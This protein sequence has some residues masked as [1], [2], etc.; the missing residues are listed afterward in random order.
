MDVTPREINEKQFRDAWR[1]YNQEEVDDFLDRVAESLDRI[2]QEN[3]STRRRNHELEQAL[4]TTR[5]TEEMLKKTLVTAQRAA[6]EAIAKAKSKAEQLVEDAEK[7][8]LG[9]NEKARR[10]IDAAEEEAHRKRLEEERKGEAKRRELDAAITRMS[11]Y[12]SDL[13]RKLRTFLEEQKLAL[14]ALVE[15]DPAPSG[16]R[17]E[18]SSRSMDADPADPLSDNGADSATARVVNVDEQVPSDEDD[19]TV[20]HRRGVR[21]L[22]FR[23]E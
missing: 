14:D 2:T 21:G 23:D 18:P 5:D 9:A 3:E 4:A 19:E 12:Q 10:I 6:E 16:H 1:G 15:S 8:A 11:A 20:G 7:R 22:F 17:N 13:Q